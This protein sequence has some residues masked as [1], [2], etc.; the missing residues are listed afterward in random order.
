ML[1]LLLVLY[2]VWLFLAGHFTQAT[3]DPYTIINRI[4]E[5]DSVIAVVHYNGILFLLYDQ[6]IIG[7]EFNDPE[8]RNQAAFPGFAI[9][10]CAAYLHEKPTRAMQIGL[11]IGTIP[12]FLRKMDIPT[13]VVEI[14]EA[15]VNQATDYFQYQLCQEEEKN[16]EFEEEKEEEEEEFEDEEEEE[17]ECFNGRTF[18]MDGLKFIASKPVDLGIQT[19]DNQQPYDLV[20]VDV[21]TGSNPFE[22]FVREEM[23]RIRDNWLRQEGVLVMNFVGYMQGFRTAAPKSIYRTLQSVFKY[24]KSFREME[25]EPDET[26]AANIVFYASD[27]PFSFDLPTTQMYENPERNTYYRVVKHFPEWEIFTELKAEVE[28]AIHQEND[29][30][31]VRFVENDEK[32]TTDGR[33]AAI[34]VLTEADHG[35]EDFREIH[36]DTQAHMRERVLDQFPSALWEDLKQKPDSTTSE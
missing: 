20:I 26:E 19:D 36:T 18:V 12:S 29:D 35:Q 15:V 28:V 21:Y 9:M 13:D 17:E 32:S 8:I 23:L 22:F 3:D 14:S 11:G 4:D 5:G 30:E 27:K 25:D 24:V 7:A 10:Q 1:S 31:D 33:T 2:A 16:Q 6:T 34:R